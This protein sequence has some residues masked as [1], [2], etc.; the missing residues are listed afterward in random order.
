MPSVA[1]TQPGHGT[2]ATRSASSFH[3]VYATSTASSATPAAMLATATQRVRV[4]VERATSRH[5][6][7][8]PAR[9]PPAQRAGERDQ[10]QDDLQ[11][12]RQR[13]AGFQLARP[14]PFREAGRL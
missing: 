13:I 5:A 2:V 10:R 7:G 14:F 9:A 4:I 3:G 11:G 6:R 12:S 1:P 8:A